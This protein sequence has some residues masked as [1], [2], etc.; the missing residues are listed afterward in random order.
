MM[1]IKFTYLYHPVPSK[2]L[3]K[4]A[5]D[6]TAF[7]LPDVAKCVLP[8]VDQSIVPSPNRDVL[9]INPRFWCQYHVL[10]GVLFDKRT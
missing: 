8:K 4:L 5:I 6:S 3:E 10:F 7:Q 2:D 9:A 1:L